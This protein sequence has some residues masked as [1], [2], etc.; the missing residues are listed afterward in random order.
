MQTLKNRSFSF[1]IVLFLSFYYVP[2]VAAQCWTKRVQV[3]LDTIKVYHQF[4][5]E[6]TPQTEL[7]LKFKVRLEDKKLEKKMN[8][9]QLYMDVVYVDYA[10]DSDYSISDTL[11]KRR[12]YTMH[13]GALESNV[14]NFSEMGFI[15]SVSF[16]YKKKHLGQMY[17]ARIKTIHPFDDVLFV[18]GFSLK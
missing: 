15:E 1:V 8:F 11:R 6:T 18:V 7:P 16:R 12:S 14:F 17:D 9:E 13:N 2:N 4:T 10:Y 3:E 5:G